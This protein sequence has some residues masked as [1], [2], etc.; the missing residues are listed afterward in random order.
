MSVVITAQDGSGDST[1]PFDI[2][3]PY[4]PSSESGNVVHPLIA[5]G[6]IA[7]TVVGE[8]PPSGSLRLI[9][10]DD[11]TAEEGRELLTRATSFS[12]VVSERPV[13]NMT[14][15]RQ[16]SLT[17]AI[18]SELDETWQFDVGFQEIEP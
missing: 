7:V 10:E 1:T 18:H 12:L 6:T 3:K 16:G 4:A 13:L 11:T 2:E 9:Y 17:R 15:V 5:P 8:L 14:F